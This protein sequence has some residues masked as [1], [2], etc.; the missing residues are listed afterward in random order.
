M[1][2]ADEIL[3]HLEKAYAALNACPWDEE[4]EVLIEKGDDWSVG[5]NVVKTGPESFGVVEYRRSDWDFEQIIEKNAKSLFNT[6]IIR[7]QKGLRGG[8]TGLEHIT[9]D[10][11][12]SKDDT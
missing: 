9:E 6:A 8:L 10:W 3:K 4:K 1:S 5:F 7:Y 2:L 11:S 12:Y